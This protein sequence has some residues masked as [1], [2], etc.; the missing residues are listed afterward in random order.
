MR[1]LTAFLLAVF[2]LI[3]LCSCELSYKA[4]AVGK[5][6]ILVYGNDYSYTAYNPEK[7]VYERPIC[8]LD[9]TN[10]N[11][12]LRPLSCTI[13]D[14]TEVGKAL[15]SLAEKSGYDYSLKVLKEY[16][17][18][19]EVSF[20]NAI[21]AIAN[22]SSENDITIIYFSCH[23]AYLD[24]KGNR[25]PVGTKVDYGIDVTTK[26]YLLFRFNSKL[27]YNVLYPV[28]TVLSKIETIKGA[29][30]VIGDFCYSGALI[31]PDYFSV[32]FGEYNE[33]DLVTLFSEYRDAIA[34]NSDLF[35]LSAARYYEESHEPNSGHGYFTKALLEGLG[36]DEEHQAIVSPR[37]EKNGRISL[38]ELAKYVTA[39]DSEP[40]W[41][42]QNPMVSGGSNDIVLFSF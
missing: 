2:L 41:A 14:A 29:K 32:T 22:D 17:E 13:K 31:L 35:C 7:L 12:S 36:W 28:S 1:R 25:I 26:A 30:V 21:E 39:N 5:M 40:S 19:D 3:V 37:A 42:S 34:V 20:E 33:M 10:T 9:G 11:Y 6:H 18:T 23:G 24:A 27:N 16:E 4:P 38:H 8:Y 15:A